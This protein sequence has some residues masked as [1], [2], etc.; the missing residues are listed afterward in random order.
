M[1]SKQFK[2]KVALSPSRIDTYLECSMKYAFKYLYKCPDTTNSGAQRGST[3]HDVFEI[4]ANKRHAKHVESV[5]KN[6]TCKEN[7]PLW[8]LICA[9]AKKYKVDDKENLDL[10][11]QFI[12]VGLSYEFFGPENTIEILTEKEFDFEYTNKSIS[13]RCKGIIDK[14]FVVK[15]KNKKYI[16]LRDF[17]SS[18]EKFS[19]SKLEYNHQ[20]NIYHLAIKRHLFPNLDLKEFQFLFLKFE[21][22]PLQV[23][24]LLSEEE[25][26]GYEVY[27]SF[28]QKKIDNFSQADE[29]S[30][31]AAHDATLRIRRCGK[32]GIKKDG[33]PNFI[34]AAQLPITYF[35]LVDA[36]GEVKK[37]SLK[38]DLKVSVGERVE[39]R[40]YAGCG[41][42]RK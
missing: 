30:N 24:P 31:Y 22:E 5:I 38:N 36:K 1:E 39:K 34:C 21:D 3:A 29:S 2:H 20:A 14:L 17:K 19:G 10:I 6:Q 11:D 13:Y 28:I 4:L 37:S 7:K 41:F 35:V 12:K 8:K 18:K 23:A 25:L 33:T 27:L 16:I 9:T 40:N 32:V 15:N 42:F 26:V